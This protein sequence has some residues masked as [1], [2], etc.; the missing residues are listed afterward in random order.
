M[1]TLKRT[2]IIFRAQDFFW[3]I[4]IVILA[5]L[6]AIATSGYTGILDDLF[7]SS[8][9]RDFKSSEGGFLVKTPAALEESVTTKNPV[10]S[11]DGKSIEVTTHQFSG[12]KD[13]LYY[14]V[15]YTD[16]PEWVFTL[17]DRSAMV[18]A[19]LGN[20]GA[21]MTKLHNG[22]LLSDMKI[23]IGEFPGREILVEFQEQ[24]QKAIGKARFYLVGR[25]MYQIM[26]YAPAGKGGM[27]DISAFLE[28]F[29]LLKVTLALLVGQGSFIAASV[30]APRSLASC[31][32]TVGVAGAPR[33]YHRSATPT[34]RS[35]SR[36]RPWSHSFR[37]SLLKRVESCF[38][39]PTFLV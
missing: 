7:S 14:S 27:S 3:R 20:A 26:V 15:G 2:L 12:G 16:F 34:Q 23:A 38:Q 10:I 39:L 29:Q 24:G 28:S 4:P 19:L 18:E 30:S 9:P 37:G 8:K 17:G 6:V 35:H 22:E 5:L 33:R 21:G 31:A 13:G 11:P 1:I 36:L 32:P 25:R